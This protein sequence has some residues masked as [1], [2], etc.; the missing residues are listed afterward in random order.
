MKKSTADT[1]WSCSL[2]KG[3]LKTLDNVQEKF[4]YAVPLSKFQVV[5]LQPTALL[6]M[7]LKFWK[8]SEIFCAVEFCITEADTAWFSTE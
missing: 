1:F 2:F 5:K 4:C 7:F 8:I 3:V 6:C